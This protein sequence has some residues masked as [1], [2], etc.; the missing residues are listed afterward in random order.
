MRTRLRKLHAH[1]REYVWRAQILHVQGEGDCHR[2]IRVRIWGAGKNS[3]ALQ[4][5]LLSKAWGTPWGACATDNAYPE[6][7]HIRAIIDYALSQG[8]DPQLVGGTFLISEREHALELDD[9]LCTDR[10][11]DPEAP[12]PT[13]RVIRSYEAAP[14]RPPRVS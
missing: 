13:A 8:W 7:R 6:P 12:D 1:G 9:F 10:L 4:V 11:R 3:R 14:P 5:D 2:C